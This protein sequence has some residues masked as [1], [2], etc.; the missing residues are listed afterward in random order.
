MYS[1]VEMIIQLDRRDSSHVCDVVSDWCISYR[2]DNLLNYGKV[3]NVRSLQKGWC[4]TT[5]RATISL[6][7]NPRLDG[8]LHADSTYTLV[9]H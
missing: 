6:I 1:P 2:S 9:Q 8:P 5:D 7:P 3:T 4:I